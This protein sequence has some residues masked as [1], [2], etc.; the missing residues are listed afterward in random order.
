MI[1]FRHI[2][3]FVICFILALLTYKRGLLNLD[4]AL[5]AFFLGLIIGF[6]GNITLII[7]LL[8]FLLSAFLATRY[9]FNYKKKIDSQEGF[10]GE[11]GWTNVLANGIVPVSV[12]LLSQSGNLISIGFLKYEYTM[13]LFVLSVAAAASDTLASEIG[14]ASDK[15]YLITTFKRVRPGTNGG[16]SLYG[17]IWA[18]IG[19]FYTFG[20]AYLLFQLENSVIFNPQ[21]ILLGTAFGFISCQIDS[22]LGATLEREGILNKSLVNLLSIS[23]TVSIFGG[24]IYVW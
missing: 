23:I 12:L 17:E 22:V 11:R 19:S 3:I 5:T 15:V 9:K 21:I 2:L 6:Q 20:V 10:K 18:F 16:I 7:L 8:I 24:L 1:I 13:I 14:M 4:G